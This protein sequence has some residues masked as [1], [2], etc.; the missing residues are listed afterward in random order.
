MEL[1]L[2]S[3]EPVAL[4]QTIYYVNNGTKKACGDVKKIGKYNRKWTT[5]EKQAYVLEH[6]KTPPFD[7]TTIEVNCYMIPE[8]EILNNP[9]LKGEYNVPLYI[10]KFNKHVEP[11]MVAFK[12]EIREGLL[13]EDPKDR[14]YFT[15][16]QCE[17]DNGHPLKESGQDNLD[18]VMTLSDT[19]VVFWNKVKRDPF[20][21]YVEDS[22]SLVDQ[23]WV[24]YNRKVVALEANSSTN[25]PEDEIINND[26]KD[27]AYHA[28]NV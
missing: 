21:M 17:L 14:Q 4:G 3:Q 26:G 10:N 1:L 11:L 22:L 25:N 19:E 6:G 20:F 9:D 27:L 16:T 5:K 15:A 18:E 2:A 23:Y 24:D 8:A 12:P 7:V 13:I 28:T